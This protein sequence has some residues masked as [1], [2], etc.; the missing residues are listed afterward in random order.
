MGIID[1]RRL[2]GSA[3]G[4][5]EA[6]DQ[7]GIGQLGHGLASESTSLGPKPGNACPDGAWYALPEL[8]QG[9]ATVKGPSVQ[10]RLEIQDLYARY[11]WALDTG[12][13]GSANWC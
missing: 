6:C 13:T 11:C 8:G 1:R 12:D 3:S 4:Q 5:G 2:R 9:H 7:A 10:D